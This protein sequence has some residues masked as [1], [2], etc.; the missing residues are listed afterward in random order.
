[1][2]QIFTPRK[3]LT[4]EEAGTV[5]VLGNGKQTE[6]ILDD[7]EEYNS[8]AR[9]SAAGSGRLLPEDSGQDAALSRMENIYLAAD[10]LSLASAE[11]YRRILG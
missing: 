1:M 6:E 2:I 11:K 8:Q 9:S 7:T 5:H 10:A 4:S 3:S